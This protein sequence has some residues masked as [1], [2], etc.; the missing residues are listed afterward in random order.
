MDMN[1][2]YDCDSGKPEVNM[3]PSSSRTK[4]LYWIMTAL[5]IAVWLIRMYIHYQ[6]KYQIKSNPFLYNSFES[7][8]YTD[9]G[10]LSVCLIILS[11]GAAVSGLA[12]IGLFANA[13]RQLR[14]HEST[15]IYALMLVPIL[16]P[17]NTLNRLLNGNEEKII[18]SLII[19]LLYIVCGVLAFMLS[20][21]L[22]KYYSGALNEL[23]TSILG[24]VEIVFFTVVA[25]ILVML[26]TFVSGND[27]AIDYVAII[28]VCIGLYILY[29]YFAVLWQMSELMDA[30]NEN[31]LTD[32][33]FERILRCHGVSGSIETDPQDTGSTQLAFK[34]LELRNK[35]HQLSSTAKVVIFAV[36]A[37]VCAGCVWLMTRNNEGQELQDDETP[38]WIGTV[39]TENEYDT[40]GNGD[41]YDNTESVYQ[42]GQTEIARLCDRAS[43]DIPAWVP[44]NIRENLVADG[45]I[46]SP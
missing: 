39:Y 11:L 21:A 34:T 41:S 30:G 17:L 13:C 44:D 37:L 22:R 35:W 32:R 9:F 46:V 3:L 19:F 8:P 40:S 45:Y 38:E 42:E 5:F 10:N 1:D 7:N 18:I 33:E 26:L 27:S 24:L 23:G 4:G 20:K 25:L 36:I 43:S 15:Y 29:R 16:L 6:I 14:H 31:G 28:S 2:Y 12:L